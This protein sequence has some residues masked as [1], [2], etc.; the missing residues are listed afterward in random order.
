MKKLEKI[1]DNSEQNL[2]YKILEKVINNQIL[3]TRINN[4][5]DNNI[6]YNSLFFGVGVITIGIICL[7]KHLI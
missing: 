2:I 7:H 4:K 6:F 3:L 5:I 1:N